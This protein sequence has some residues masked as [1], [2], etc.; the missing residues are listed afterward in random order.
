MRIER[1]A[2]PLAAAIES[3]KNDRAFETRRHELAGAADF[4]ELR[5]S[6]LVG[7]GRAARQHVLGERLPREGR[8]LERERLCGRSHFAVHFGTLDVA[9]LD[10]K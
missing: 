3:G 8:R 9:V 10:G 2:A 1:C 4:L 6:G 7:I 5:Q